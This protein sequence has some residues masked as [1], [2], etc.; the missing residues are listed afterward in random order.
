MPLAD[1]PLPATAIEIEADVDLGVTS[2]LLDLLVT[3]DRF[4]RRM[5][6]ARDGRTMTVTMSL[7]P[8]A[9]NGGRLLAKMRQI[10]GVRRADALADA[11]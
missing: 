10:P 5:D 1:A 9:D 2:R 7:P 4:P 6:L 3:H 8:A 11:P